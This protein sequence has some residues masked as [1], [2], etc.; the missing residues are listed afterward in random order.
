M[1]KSLFDVVPDGS[2]NGEE[3]SRDN[4]QHKE[5][6]KRVLIAYDRCA[7]EACA[8]ERAL[9]ALAVAERDE[10]EGLHADLNQRASILTRSIAVKALELAN[11]QAALL[12]MAMRSFAPSPEMA[13]T[14]LDRDE[15][16]LLCE[17][18]QSCDT[19]LCDL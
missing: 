4:A 9:T 15:L 10:P 12:R 18:S 13:G 14:G 19:G 6:I 3:A 1:V 8:Y 5:A 2:M 16:R 17:V 11:A 7:S